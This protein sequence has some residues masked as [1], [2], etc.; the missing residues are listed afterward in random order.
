M[1]SARGNA[2]TGYQV[3]LHRMFLQ[4]SDGIWRALVAYLRDTDA[5]ASRAIRAYI[6]QQHPLLAGLQPAPQCP[7]LLQPQGRYFDLEAIYDDLINT[8]SSIACKRTL[9]GVADRHSASAGPY[10]LVPIRSAIG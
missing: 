1:L 2:Q 10:A 7:R 6:R 4:A 9:P 8:I 3:R 5:T